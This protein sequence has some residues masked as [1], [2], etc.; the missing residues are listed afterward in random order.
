MNLEVKNL[1]LQFYNYLCDIIGS[2][3]V[4]RTRREI[5]TAKDIVDNTTS[6][7]LISS[8]SKAEGLDLKGSDFDNMIQLNF[9]RVYECLDDVHC[10]KNKLVMETNDTKPG[11]TKL[12][13]VDKSLL[14]FDII[15]NFGEILGEEIYISSKRFRE[16]FLRDGMIIH[17][18]CQSTSDGEFDNALCL[19]CEEWITL[20]QQWIQ[21]SR[22][23]WPHYKLVTSAVHIKLNRCDKS[24]KGKTIADSNAQNV[25][26]LYE[27]QLRQTNNSYLTTKTYMKEVVV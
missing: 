13:L 2:E 4:V 12:K 21:R 6:A 7:T 16:F 19:R 14:D 23:T 26:K 18:P 15:Q 3:E 22:A 24:F 5:F 9:V 8:G 11:F 1:S 27:K 17:G 20:A 25:R 10:D